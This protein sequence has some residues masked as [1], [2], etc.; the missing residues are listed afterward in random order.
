MLTLVGAMIALLTACSG[1][2]ASKAPAL[3]P[4]GVIALLDVIDAVASAFPDSVI[5]AGRLRVLPDSERQ[6]LAA[7][8]RR[9][10]ETNPRVSAALERLM[11]T[12]AYRLYF[13]RFHNITPDVFRELV[14][15]LPYG[16]GSG[17]GGI[18]EMLVGLVGKRREVR[19][20]VERFVAHAEMAD[21]VRR[22]M[23]WAPAG[24]RAPDRLFLIYDSNAG[25][26]TAG[27]I[28]FFNLY[29]DVDLDALSADTSG[30]ALEGAV[31]V[32]AHELQHTIV[33]PIL[34]ASSR[35]Q[36]PWQ[37][38]WLDRITRGL[39][40]EGM[41]IHCNP[42]EGFR[43]EL[44]ED[45]SVVR[46]LV[47]R[48]N[49]LL[50]DVGNNHATED[51]VQTWYRENLFGFAESLLVRFLVT[52]YSGDELEAHRRRYMSI[53]PDLEH[54]LGWWMV[55]RISEEG[56]AREVALD[57]LSDPYALY[58]RYNDAAG[59]DLLI[60]ESALRAIASVRG[61]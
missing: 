29:G 37:A 8:A 19:S 15:N 16:A 7:D 3:E 20:A 33:A 35:P 44:W 56:R 1:T 54:V 26:F 60:S 17:P 5:E 42:P 45:T 4:E 50:E 43:K 24:S 61:E 23:E 59:P 13:S 55:A 2:P 40:S 39:V 14:L 22:A 32:M 57:L 48:L 9:R 25:S 51:D 52:R 36:S 47:A 49:G 31:S 21:V 41:A 18:G 53:R 27:S 6:L 11:A 28:P 10:N 38:L 30:A 34:F 46:A 58:V 12:E